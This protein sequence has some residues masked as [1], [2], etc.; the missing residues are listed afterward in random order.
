MRFKS[1]RHIRR[2]LLRRCER[3]LYSA[4]WVQPSAAVRRSL[5][6]DASALVTISAIPLGPER[7]QR[8]Y[9]LISITCNGTNDG[10]TVEPNGTRA[11]RFE[12]GSARFRCGSVGKFLSKLL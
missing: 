1:A 10:T 9:S 4:P 2:Q 7:H 8:N 11:I 5:S 6:R 3:R 12:I